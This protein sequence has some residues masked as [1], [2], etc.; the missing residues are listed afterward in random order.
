MRAGRPGATETVEDWPAMLARTG[1]PTPVGSRTF[2]TEHSPP[3]PGAAREHLHAHLTRLRENMAE[4]LAPDDIDTLDALLDP[5]APTG[6]RHRPD[7][8]Y[9]TATTVHAARVD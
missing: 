8:F 7:A 2:L 1:G 9:L 6:I 5:D 3:L 4:R